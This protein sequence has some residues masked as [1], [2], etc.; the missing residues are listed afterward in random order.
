MSIKKEIKKG[1]LKLTRRYHKSSS[2]GHSSGLVYNM[3]MEMV[4]TN[5]LTEDD[6]RNNKEFVR[7]MRQNPLTQKPT[8]IL[9]FLPYGDASAF[10]AGGFRTIMALNNALSKTWKATVYL[11]FFPAI[12]DKKLLEKFKN[13]VAAHFPDLHYQ[14]VPFTEVFDLQVDVAMCNFWLGAYP[15]VKFNNCKEKYNLVQDHESLFYPS[16]II[17]ALA[18]QTLKFGFYKLT[19]SQ[20]LKKYL[21]F[22]DPQ[23]PAFRYLPGIDHALYY[24]PADKNYRKDVYKI[25]LYG[26]PSIPRNAFD[27]L[28]PV[29]KNIKAVLGDKI[30][31]ISAGEDYD[32]AFYG[33]KG[34]VRNI[35]KVKSLQELAD[36][37]RQCDIG[38]SLITTPTFSYQHLEFMASGLCLVTNLQDGVRDF[39]QDGENAVVSEL[40]P[41]IL[42]QKI[43]HLVNHPELMEKI[44]Q[45]AIHFASGLDWKNCFD[46]IAGFMTSTKKG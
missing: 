3:P 1:F 22:K 9:C 19:N 41:Y 10:L 7:R 37:Y 45:N 15:L 28:V 35:G 4:I 16:G 24:P 40:T 43:I 8:S 46:S 39:L 20:A 44:S 34:I 32:A 2:Y 13:N 12:E 11:C 27:L 30:D 31:I 6:I 21:E 26:R 5:M 17:A 42:S 36:L 14:L 25:I 18:E 38:V 23:A 29:C 33:L